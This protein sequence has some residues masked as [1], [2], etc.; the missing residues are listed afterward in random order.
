MRNRVP[1]DTKADHVIEPAR[2]THALRVVE[3]LVPLR[4]IVLPER[5]VAA[6]LDL[7][8]DRRVKRFLHVCVILLQLLLLLFVFFCRR[9]GR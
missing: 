2:F 6:E 3:L 5:P 4:L 7:G 1:R 8:D 9:S